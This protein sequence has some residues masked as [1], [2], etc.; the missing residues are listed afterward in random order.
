MIT[1]HKDIYPPPLQR[2]RFLPP[3]PYKNRL[4]I[5]W[6][7]QCG[8]PIFKVNIFHLLVPLPLQ[9]SNVIL[10]RHSL[11]D[12]SYL[13]ACFLPFGFTMT[14]NFSHI[15]LSDSCWLSIT[16]CLWVL[17]PFNN[18]ST[19]LESRLSVCTRW[20]YTQKTYLIMLHCFCCQSKELSQN[21]LVHVPFLLSFNPLYPTSFINSKHFSTFYLH[22]CCF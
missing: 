3:I 21:T 15:C 18:Q 8:W 10:W 4:N 17:L 20:G 5:P 7:H 22:P 13:V 12:Q 9:A 11:P 6:H 14:F 16:K 2:I 1:I 19:V